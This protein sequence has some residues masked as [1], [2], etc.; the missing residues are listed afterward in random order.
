MKP[1][2]RREEG[3]QG[4]EGAMLGVGPQHALPLVVAC[5]ICAATVLAVLEGDEP[6]K[7]ISSVATAYAIEGTTATG[8]EARVGI[9]AVDPSVIPLGSKIRVAGAGRY[10]GTYWALDTGRN[11]V[12]NRIDIYMD[13]REEAKEFGRRTVEVAVLTFGKQEG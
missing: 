13:S 2:A 3:E 4:P 7:V 8:D 1:A 9:V 5:A 12:G 11:I 10:S 6:Q